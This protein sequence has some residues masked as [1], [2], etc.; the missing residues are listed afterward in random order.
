MSSFAPSLRGKK[1]GVG[2]AHLPLAPFFFPI[3]PSTSENIKPSQSENGL[4]IAYIFD[5]SS[6]KQRFRH[7]RLNI[8]LMLL[9]TTARSPKTAIER[10]P[11]RS[12]LVKR[13]SLAA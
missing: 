4:P 6:S 9:A 1:R 13:Q 3:L 7:Y 5:F 11:S 12:L 10:P 2:V 8:T